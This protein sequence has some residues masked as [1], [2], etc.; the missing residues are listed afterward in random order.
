MALSVSIADRLLD[1]LAGEVGTYSLIFGEAPMRRSLC[2]L[3]L[4]RGR[5]HVRV[6]SGGPE[7]PVTRGDEL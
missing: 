1:W 4:T 5:E 3:S 2:V 7:A 6:A